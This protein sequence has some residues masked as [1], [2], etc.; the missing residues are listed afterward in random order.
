MEAGWTPPFDDMER[1]GGFDIFCPFGNKKMVI[2]DGKMDPGEQ[3]KDEE[4]QDIHPPILDNAE[5]NPI[6]QDE[7]DIKD[8]A[9]EELSHLLARQVCKMSCLRVITR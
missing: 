4:E 1:K 9:G 7:P 6:P 5:H 3:D 8:M 2:M